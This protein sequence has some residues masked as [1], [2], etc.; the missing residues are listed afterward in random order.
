LRNSG[1]KTE[2]RTLDLFLTMEVLYQL[3]YLGVMAI[4][5]HENLERNLSV[6]GARFARTPTGYEP[7]EVLLLQPA[8]VNSIPLELRKSR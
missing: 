6:A 4:I 1:A 3:S 5:L 2:D 8:K 7:V